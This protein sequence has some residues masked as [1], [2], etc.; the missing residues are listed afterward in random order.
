MINSQVY[1]DCV[2]EYLIGNETCTFMTYVFFQFN[3]S[4]PHETSLIIWHTI[5]V[6]SRL[7]LFIIHMKYA[8]CKSN[9][10]W[11]SWFKWEMCMYTFGHGFFQNIELYGDNDQGFLRS[12]LRTNAPKEDSV[13]KCLLVVGGSG[14]KP[15]GYLTKELSQSMSY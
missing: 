12:W 4:Y 8:L 13:N 9:R 14:A 5:V 7:N 2:N 15:S 3:S 6:L 11:S 10:S 1:K